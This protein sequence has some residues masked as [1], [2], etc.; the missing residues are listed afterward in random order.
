MKY[1]FVFAISLLLILLTAC[2][3]SSDT[4]K[5]VTSTE[6]DQTSDSESLISSSLESSGNIY[7]IFDSAASVSSRPDVSSDIPTNGGVSSYERDTAEINSNFASFQKALKNTANQKQYALTA[8]YTLKIGSVDILKIIKQEQ[9]AL[10]D[11]QQIYFASNERIE[12]SETAAPLARSLSQTYFD[13]GSV[14]TRA[15]YEDSQNPEYNYDNIITNTDNSAGLEPVS[16]NYLNLNK[17]HIMAVDTTISDQTTE[18]AFTMDPEK[19]RELLANTLNS[20]EV[21]FETDHDDLIV[22]YNIINAK[23]D[24]NGY[25]TELS[26]TIKFIIIS[27][28]NISSTY[29]NQYSYSG[30]GTNSEVKRPEWIK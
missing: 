17:S 26:Q 16:Y 22:E 29:T 19:S 7:G 23:A 1:I 8:D 6:A 11:K 27:A 2:S 30:I 28:G 21:G 14:Y 24:S 10:K 13:G 20:D 25:I 3:G 5:Y 15:L 18:Y 9:T 4:M 12:K